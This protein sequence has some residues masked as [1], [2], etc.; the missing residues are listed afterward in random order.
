MIIFP[1]KIKGKEDRLSITVP[2]RIAEDYNLEPG[3]FVLVTLENRPVDPLLK[4]QFRKRI[5]KCGYEG[6]LLYIPKKTVK[7][8]DLRRE[9]SVIVS[10]EEF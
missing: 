9:M 6:L 3:D 10:L 7:E 2:K 4:I 5:A 8:Y 1:K